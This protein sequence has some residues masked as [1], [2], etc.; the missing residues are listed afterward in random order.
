MDD[1]R[2]LSIN[3]WTT[4]EQW[5]LREA[6]EGY[7]RHGVHGIAIVRDKLLEIGANEAA[8]ILQDNNMT[9]TGYCIGGLLTQLDDAKFQ[10]SLD[11]NRRIIDEAATIGAQCIVV[12]AGGLEDGSKDLIA[13]RGRCLEGLDRLLPHARNAGIT[14]ALEPLHPM[15]CAFRSC[16]TT[17]GQAN[18]WCEALGTGP[19][20]GVAVDVYHVWW[21][22][23]MEQEIERAKGRIAAFHI[24]DWLMDTVDLRLDRGMMGDGVIDIPRIRKLV[25][26]SGYQGHREVEIF[27]A[28]NWWQ[29][30]PDEVVEVVKERYL[31]YV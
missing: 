22:P 6:I 31:R 21:D 12:V 3:Q 13:A 25:E 26:A 28:R 17:L 27:S 18:D 7:V 8:R 23:Q 9:V 1:Y 19:E 14:L 24:C 10:E 30:D 2:Q 29:R 16:L 5:T 11:D 20:L 4:I 15:T